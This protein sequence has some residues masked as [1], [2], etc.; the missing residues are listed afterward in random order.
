M[1]RLACACARERK[2]WAFGRPA[3]SPHHHDHPDGGG[4]PS[5]QS[6]SVVRF[7]REVLWKLRRTGKLTVE[8][9]DLRV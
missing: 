8:P 1:P 5:T 7:A 2:R 9:A 6:L 4:V 3:T